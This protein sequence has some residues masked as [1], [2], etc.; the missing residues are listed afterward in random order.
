MSNPVQLKRSPTTSLQANALS[1]FDTIALAISGT[2][3]SYTLNATTATLMAAVGLAAPAAIL[4]GAIPMFGIAFAFKHLNRWRTD[5][6]AAYAWVGRSINPYLGFLCA[7]TFLVLSTAFIVAGSLPVGVM[8]L[9]L[10]APAYQDNVVLATLIA[11]IWFMGVAIMTFLGV[12]L[13]AQVQ[14]LRT[15][16]EAIALGV[17]SMG[18]LV[19]FSANPVNPF[20]WSWFSPT[21]F[22]TGSTF[23]AGMLIAVFYYFGWDVSSN[24]AEE[25]QNSKNVPG[26]GGLMGMLGIVALFLLVQVGLQMGLSAE[27][28]E[29]NGAALLPAFGDAVLP[30]PWGRIA[31]LAALLSTVGTLETQITQ[32][33]RLLF[34]M[35]RDRVIYHGFEEIHPRFK[36]PWLAGWVVTGLGL[37]LMVLSSASASIGALME[38]LIS[39]IGVMVA[40]YYGLSGLACAWYYR[41]TLGKSRKTLVTQGL[42]P[43][44]SAVFLLVLAA[45]QLP[46]L[47]LTVALYTVGSIALGVI[48]M[49]YYRRRYNSSF[50]RSPSEYNRR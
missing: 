32:S 6:G 11:A 19:K 46:Q 28:V 21:S 26:D 27:V 30:A 43:V 13:T 42:W 40:F 35:G 20:S 1:L 5:A 9:S 34:S 24:V 8:T 50:Y 3:P 45:M 29:K 10:I 33:A 2:A 23:M 22:G 4:L 47:G 15:A 14:R 41:R 16:I 49:L 38:S 39:A 18:A 37:V 7:W 44:A 17:L 25:T 31:L 36:T 48:P 12:K